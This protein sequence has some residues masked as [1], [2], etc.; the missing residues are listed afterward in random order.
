MLDPT[1]ARLLKR[2]SKSELQQ[3]DAYN[4]C[5]SLSKNL[6]E[7]KNTSHSVIMSPV[8]EEIK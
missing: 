3:N 1:G 5:S 8:Y 7:E 6:K 2:R 4:I